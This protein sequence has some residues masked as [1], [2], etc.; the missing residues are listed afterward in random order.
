LPSFS[1]ACAL[2]RGRGEA[3]ERRSTLAPL[4]LVAI[5]AAVG[6]GSALTGTGGAVLLVPALLWLRLPILTVVG[7]SQAIQVPIALLATLGNLVYG[8]V[9]G[10]LFV[11]VS[12]GVV[13]GC[14]GGARIAHA[15]PA[16]VL[17]R[18]VGGVLLAVGAL[19]I[20][21]AAA[22]G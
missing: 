5:G 20:F 21:R 16:P 12:T 2:R 1:L 10:A 13:V 3:G 14:W 11:L 9:D 4:P 7:L 19:L 18:F 17:T 6:F 22:L 15:L 8:A